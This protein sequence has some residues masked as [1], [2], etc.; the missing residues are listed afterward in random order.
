MI[1]YSGMISD[2]NSALLDL[3]VTYTMYTK[4]L[5]RVLA[6][7]REISNGFIRASNLPYIE[8]Q[9]TPENVPFRLIA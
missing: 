7:L 2:Y 5:L 8:C 6:L 3:V 9:I 1:Y 4:P